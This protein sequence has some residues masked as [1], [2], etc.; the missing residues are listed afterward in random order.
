MK[1]SF[2][3]GVVLSL[4]WPGSFKVLTLLQEPQLLQ[5]TMGRVEP[6][7]LSPGLTLRTGN[8][9]VLPR[10]HNGTLT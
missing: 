8:L 9:K 5:E 4:R 1:T 10:V 2:G 3:V 6:G 7:A